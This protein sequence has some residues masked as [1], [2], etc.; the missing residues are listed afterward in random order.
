MRFD[1]GINLFFHVGSLVKRSSSHFGCRLSIVYQEPS[2]N[3]NTIICQLPGFSE[4][5]NQEFAPRRGCGGKTYP[6][7]V[8]YS[9]KRSPRDSPEG[10]EQKLYTKLKPRFSHCCLHSIQSWGDTSC[11]A[12]TEANF[13]VIGLCKFVS[14]RPLQRTIQLECWNS[15]V[16]CSRE[17]PQHHY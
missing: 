4:R 13:R 6:D 12:Q 3:V 2:R 14:R 17:F 8:D 7:D 11:G 15:R 1:S 16:F 10:R 5:L 9:G